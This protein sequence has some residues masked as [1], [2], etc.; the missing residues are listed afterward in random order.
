MLAMWE[1]LAS[2]PGPGSE[3][4]TYAPQIPLPPTCGSILSEATPPPPR[5]WLRTKFRPPIPGNSNL[6]MGKDQILICD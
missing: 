2:S 1:K 5:E 4:P 3:A 6:E